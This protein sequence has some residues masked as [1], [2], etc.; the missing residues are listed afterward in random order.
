[1]HGC[2]N[3]FVVIDARKLDAYPWREKAPKIL[4]RRFG[5]GGDSLLVVM[6]SNDAPAKMTIFEKDG[7]ESEACGNGIRCVASFVR[8]KDGYFG[9]D[10]RIETLAGTKTVSF[11]G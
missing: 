7:R 1:M 4:E 6:P 8:K 5:V 9:D 11:S 3:D 2:G 10:M